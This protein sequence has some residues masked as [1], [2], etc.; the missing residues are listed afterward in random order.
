MSSNRQDCLAAA[1]ESAKSRLPTGCTLDTFCAGLDGWDALPVH[2]SGA[3]IGA[4]LSKGPELHA[5]IQPV[6][7]GRWF[8]RQHFK[9]IDK[10]ID[11]YGYALT[12]TTTGNVAGAAF[13]KRLGF[14]KTTERDGLTVYKKV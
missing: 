8:G 6:A 5:C 9:L 12:S 2:V 13:V 7:F 3:L 14:E 4:V 1:Y 11:E 10:A